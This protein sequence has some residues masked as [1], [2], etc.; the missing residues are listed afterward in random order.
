MSENRSIRNTA[1]EILHLFTFFKRKLLNASLRATCYMQKTFTF[2]RK[3]LTGKRVSV[4]DDPVKICLKDP[5]NRLELGDLWN[6]PHWYKE[7]TTHIVGINSIDHAYISSDGVI[8]KN[9]EPYKESIVYPNFH[10]RFSGQYPINQLVNFLPKKFDQRVFLIWDHWGKNNYF[11]WIIDSLSKLEICLKRNENITLVLFEHMPRFIFNTLQAYPN[12]ELLVVPKNTIPKFSEVLLPSYPISSGLC[13]PEYIQGVRSKLLLHLSNLSFSQTLP[14]SEII[15]VSRSKQK[16]RS[17]LNEDE[18]LKELDPFKLSVL[19]FE[20]Y[21]FWEQVYMMS[22][23]RLL[24][25]S[26]GSNL[27]NMLFMQENSTIIEINQEDTSTATLCYWSLANALLFDYYY[28]AVENKAGN[29]YMGKRQKQ[30]IAKL[31]EIVN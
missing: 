30:V 12:V 17:I 24:I 8:F 10:K 2:I 29:Y 11:H 6:P 1:R 3:D 20:D 22:K 27:V 16:T 13:V 31:I 25:A 4:I 15:Y 9:F 7:H 18:L 19:H 21:T 23:A 14:V 28:I 26:H 5:E